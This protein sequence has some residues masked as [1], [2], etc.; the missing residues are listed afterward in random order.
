MDGTS[1]HGIRGKNKK[2]RRPAGTGRRQFELRGGENRQSMS[3][4]SRSD[5]E[6]QQ[7][8]R[9]SCRIAVPPSDSTQSM[10]STTP[11]RDGLLS[12]F[13]PARDQTDTVSVVSEIDI[14]WN[15]KY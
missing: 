2:V 9:N 10:G 14:L 11:L 7:F 1:D 3:D 5:H 12:N 13:R 15:S 8:E 4:R 6:G